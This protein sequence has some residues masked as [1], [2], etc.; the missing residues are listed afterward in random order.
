MLVEKFM[1]IVFDET[2]QN[3]QEN[4]K[5]GAEDEIPTG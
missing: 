1:H 3:M 2:N 4:S 5:T